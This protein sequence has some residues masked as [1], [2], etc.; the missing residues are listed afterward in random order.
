MNRECERSMDPNGV[1][2]KNILITGAGRNMGASN[3]EHFAEQGVKICLGDLDLEAAEEVDDRINVVG[4]F[5][6][7]QKTAYEITECDWSSECA[8]PISRTTKDELDGSF[9]TPIAEER[10]AV[11][12]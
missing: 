8:L 2:G 9:L 6:F 12:A 5:F 10:V 7:K 3:A 1:E 11:R 4:I